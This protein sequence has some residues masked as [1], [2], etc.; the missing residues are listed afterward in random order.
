M[1]TLSATFPDEG[2]SS[3]LVSLATSSTPR[4]S[5]CGCLATLQFKVVLYL[6]IDNMIAAPELFNVVVVDA[7]VLGLWWSVPTLPCVNRKSSSNL[8]VRILGG[9]LFFCLLRVL[10]DPYDQFA[11]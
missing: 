8:K 4:C 9:E 2:Q 10:C 7:G 1:Y 11:P 5:Y 3:S 6:K